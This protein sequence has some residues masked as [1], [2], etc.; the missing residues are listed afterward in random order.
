MGEVVAELRSQIVRNEFVVGTSPAFK[1][2]LETIDTIASRQCS[3]I[4]SGETGAGK[5]IVAHRIGR[6]NCS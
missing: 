1:S 4:I 3:M 5:E 6:R 2:I